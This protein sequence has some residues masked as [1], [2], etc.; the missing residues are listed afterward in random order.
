[1]KVKFVTCNISRDGHFFSTVVDLHVPVGESSILAK[2]SR[3]TTWLL[4]TFQV[5]RTYE[6]AS[7]YRGPSPGS[8][9]V[10]FILHN[11]FMCY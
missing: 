3:V 1:M 11:D 5:S 4:R 2:V 8:R 7:L 10:E 9:I 6:Q